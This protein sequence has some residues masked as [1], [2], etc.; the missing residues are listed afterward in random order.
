M[1]PGMMI[2]P[3]GEIPTEGV[4]ELVTSTRIDWVREHCQLL[5]DISAEFARTRPFEGLTI[6]TGIHLEA[7]TAA[8]ILTLRDGG[9][10]I[11]STG[12]LNST[13][14]DAVRHTRNRSDRSSRRSSDRAARTTSGC[15]TTRVRR[16]PLF[17]G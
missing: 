13:Q 16:T 8:L 11:V 9:A 7:K 4:T 17:A 10:Q 6:G 15:S 3:G 12:N 14:P 1:S 2:M 5:R